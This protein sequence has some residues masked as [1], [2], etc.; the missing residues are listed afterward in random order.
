MRISFGVFF[1]DCLHFV[2]EE[3]AMVNRNGSM[4]KNDHNLQ[5]LN[6]VEYKDNRKVIE[7]NRSWASKA[8]FSFFFF[9]VKILGFVY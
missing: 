5:A 7:T 4:E 3:V 9:L 6:C 8:A 1:L 2:L